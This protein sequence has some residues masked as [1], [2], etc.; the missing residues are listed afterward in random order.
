[1]SIHFRCQCGKQFRVKDTHAGREIQCPHCH[2]VM[3]VPTAAE[4]PNVVPPPPPDDSA[5]PVPPPLPE[6]HTPEPQMGTWTTTTASIPD[7]ILRK[8][9]CVDCGKKLTWFNRAYGAKKEQCSRCY[10]KSQKIF[11]KESI[12]RDVQKRGLGLVMLVRLAMMGAATNL[13][14]GGDYWDINDDARFAMFW[15]V[16]LIWI[17]TE[18]AYA[19][20]KKSDSKRRLM[21]SATG[22]MLACAIAVLVGGLFL[23]PA[24][25]ADGN[26]QGRLALFAFGTVVGLPVGWLCAVA[27]GLRQ[28]KE[29]PQ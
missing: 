1:M 27:F 26:A 9:T 25:N 5:R 7:E 24:A 2:N 21:L 16:L 29:S 13:G 12:W 4:P 20:L 28:P 10:Q 18:I 22:I 15:I 23:M 3:R 17:P 6:S 14:P 11:S 19:L 8:G